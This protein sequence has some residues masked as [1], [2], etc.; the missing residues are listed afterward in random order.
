MLVVW[1]RVV[2][3]TAFAAAG[4]SGPNASVDAGTSGDAD[5]AGSD[6]AAVCAQD[7]DNDGVCDAV[8]LCPTVFDPGQADLDGDGTGWVCDP[9]ESTTIQ[10]SASFSQFRAAFDGHTFA[11]S[12]SLDC[13]SGTCKQ[14]IVALSPYGMSL[15]RSD[16]GLPSDAWA[17]N[18]A[19]TPYVLPGGDLLW[20][21][22][23]DL[24][25]LNLAS[26][27]FT[28]LRNEIVVDSNFRAWN[29]R[30][31]AQLLSVRL[32]S[33]PAANL[34]RP[35]N[36]QL[37]PVT[38]AADG[39]PPPDEGFAL[40][41]TPTPGRIVVP[42]VTGSMISLKVFNVASKTLEPVMIDGAPAV[43]LDQ[44]KVLAYAS[45][46]GSGFNML[47]LCVRKAGITYLV[48]IRHDAITA[49]PMPFSTCGVVDT[50]SNF[51]SSSAST[52]IVVGRTASNAIAFAFERNGQVTSVTT[53]ITGNASVRAHGT[54]LPV[55]SVLAGTSTRVWALT[56]NG[57]AVEVPH[58]LNNAAVSVYGDTVHIA[59]MQNP[60]GFGPVV[61]TRYREATGVQSV[62]TSTNRPSSTKPEVVTTAEGAAVVSDTDVAAIVPSG[63]MTPVAAPLDNA[64]GGVRGSLT[65]LFGRDP[66][67]G[68]SK[69][70]VLAYDEVNGAPRFT[71]LTPELQVSSPGFDLIDPPN[72]T[73]PWFSFGTHDDCHTA[74]AV[75]ANGTP[76][77]E[78]HAAT[79]MWIVGIR[80][81][82]DWVMMS[83]E[84]A[85]F[86][87][88]NNTLIRVA[89]S[90]SQAFP[91]LE[92][93]H[94]TAFPWPVVGWQGAD[95]SG[96]FACL[97]SHPDRCWTFP[98]GLDSAR[99]LDASANDDSFAL[100]SWSINGTTAT[101]SIVRSIGN[102]NRPQP[103]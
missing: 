101:E 52:Y 29:R 100:M 57:T 14:A 73:S 64:D 33:I 85:V 34:M 31:P 38:A 17:A 12:L 19:A 23:A 98:S 82:G 56:S 39:F 21:R 16:S 76:A 32:S 41:E 63:S 67:V 60:T 81:N 42:E 74:R 35:E 62:V 78:E 88:T 18:E 54:S 40:H 77:L 15:A 90:G 8:D 2:W 65:V 102:G 49:H 53:N 84:N 7:Q 97:A 96:S 3:L 66:S 9:V 22:G 86:T 20:S 99:F 43:G 94:G 25:L 68:T 26:S 80:N 51:E 46:R 83:V 70:R 93:I 71:P 10:A 36:G 103:L 13:M 50:V 95:A 87:A 89:Q 45:L 75:Y 37:V 30:P 5:D 79:C 1:W 92:M 72:G 61:L 48:R 27:Q 24:G 4:C 47:P 59:G 91:R 58:T 6:D 69:P 11:S 55:A 28:V 44:L